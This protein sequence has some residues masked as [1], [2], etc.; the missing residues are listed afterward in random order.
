MNALV[1]VESRLPMPVGVDE[2]DGRK[3]RVL[4]ETTFP[5]ANTPEAIVMALDYCR[6]RGLDVFKR[7]VHIVPMWNSSLKKNVETVWPGIN[8]IQITASRTGQWAGMDEPRWGPEITRTFKGQRK[9][10]EGWE[11]VEV[12]VQFPEWCAV[13]VYRLINGH[14]C[15]FTEPVFW[16]EAYSRSGGAKSELPTEMWVKRPRGQL[17]KV[18]KAAALRAAFPEEG[19]YTAEEM[20]GKEIEQG[21]VVVEHEPVHPKPTAPSTPINPQPVEAPH[22]P[23]TGE[24]GPHEIA[25]PEDERGPLYLKWGTLFIAAVNGAASADEL[26]AWEHA[27]GP[28]I[29][30]ISQKAP[31]I[32]QRIMAN[33]A[34]ARARLAPDAEPAPKH[35]GIPPLLDRRKKADKPAPT[36]E[37]PEEWLAHIEATL[38]ACKTPEDLDTAWNDKFAS[39]LD[40]MF[41]PDATIAQKSYETHSRRLSR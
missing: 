2:I 33:V 30:A 15:P 23:D 35:D 17:H 13:T 40:D 16:L 38:V 18:A 24:I 36:P 39:R 3:W 25:V 34:T 8:E 12:A 32:Y 27:N 26:S 31:K 9:G 6:A 14:R 11:S 29:E 4:C 22:D 10:R 28:T 20:E 7:P 41:P 21:G 5:N 1:K 37:Q 19:E